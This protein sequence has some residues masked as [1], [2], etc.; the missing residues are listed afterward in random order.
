MAKPCINIRELQDRVALHYGKRPVQLT[1]Y[2]PMPIR[3]QSPSTK[4]ER[5][6]RT[7]VRGPKNMMALRLV[8]FAPEYR[9][10]AYNS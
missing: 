6:V 3:A 5:E 1:F 10:I 4:S 8:P 9:E 2:V 7:Q